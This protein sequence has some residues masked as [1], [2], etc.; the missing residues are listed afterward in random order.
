MK[1]LSFPRYV[2]TE[3]GDEKCKLGDYGVAIV[4]DEDEF[5]AA[6]KEGYK[7]NITDL[8]EKEV[9]KK[10][11]IKPGPKKFKDIKPSKKAEKTPEKDDF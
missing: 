7:E 8:F 9:K 10:A 4:D 2:F 5:K 3:K 1:E 6:L 11:A